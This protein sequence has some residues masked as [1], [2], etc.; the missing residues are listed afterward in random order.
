MIWGFYCSRNFSCHTIIR[1]HCLTPLNPFLLLIDCFCFVF[2][3]F[4]AQFLGHKESHT[5]IKHEILWKSQSVQFILLNLHFSLV[6]F[7][8]LV[9]FIVVYCQIPPHSLSENFSSHSW[10]YLP[11]EFNCGFSLSMGRFL[12]LKIVRLCSSD[13]RCLTTKSAVDDST[14]FLFFLEHRGKL[15]FACREIFLLHVWPGKTFLRATT[16]VGHLKIKSPHCACVMCN[17]FIYSYIAV[18]VFDFH[19]FVFHFRAS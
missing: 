10:F 1:H 18:L 14:Y 2:V 17:T 19:F 8:C 3:L 11:G 16:L 4:S 9:T 5:I 12:F 7:S 13:F 15:I 6:F